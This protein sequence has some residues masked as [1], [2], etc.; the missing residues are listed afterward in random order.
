MFACNLK[1]WEVCSQK[2]RE[3]KTLTWS[4]NFPDSN[5]IKH[6]QSSKEPQDNFQEN[7]QNIFLSS[8]QMLLKTKR[9]I[10]ENGGTVTICLVLQNKHTVIFFLDSCFFLQSYYEFL[11]VRLTPTALFSI[12]HA[13]E[14]FSVHADL[15]FKSAML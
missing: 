10:R 5:S 11:N 2:E 13:D 9:T 4:L 6:S 3:P 8:I 7:P 15:H 12:C 1:Y 14:E